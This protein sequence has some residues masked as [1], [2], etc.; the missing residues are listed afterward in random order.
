MLTT[1]LKEY[2]LVLEYLLIFVSF[3]YLIHVLKKL[4]W[5]VSY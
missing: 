5:G 4:V 2:L 3:A 1:Y